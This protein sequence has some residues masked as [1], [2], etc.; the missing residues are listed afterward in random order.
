MGLPGEPV[1]P[2]MGTR[3]EMYA[4]SY[5]SSSNSP[6]KFRFSWMKMPLLVSSWLCTGK[7]RVGS[8]LGTT[9]TGQVSAP[10][11]DTSFSIIQPATSKPMPG[12]PPL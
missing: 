12:A 3:T 10:T 5:T 4:N 7:A 8:G 9:S 1:A 2:L 6:S 11:R